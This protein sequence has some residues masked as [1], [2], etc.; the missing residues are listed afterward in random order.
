MQTKSFPLLTE[1][2]ENSDDEFTTPR[3]PSLL[4]QAP[5]S[6]FGSPTFNH[7]STLDKE[8]YQRTARQS[9]KRRIPD[10]EHDDQENAT[11]ITESSEGKG[12]CLQEEKTS[13][14]KRPC[15]DSTAPDAAEDKAQQEVIACIFTGLSKE[16]RDSFYRNITRVIEAGLLM[17]H[18]QDQPFSKETT[19]IITNIDGDALRKTDA[20]LCP[21]MLKY[22]HGMISGSWIVRHEWFVDS[23]NTRTWIPLPHRDYLIQGDTQ[24]GPAPGTQT[25]REIRSRRSLKLF[26][27]SRM[28]F[29]GTFGS[30]GQRAFTKDELLRLLR[31]GGAETSQRRPP[32]KRPPLS[33]SRPVVFD[34][35]AKETLSARE[36]FSSDRSFLY[37]SEDIKPWEVPIDRAA[38]II[39]CDPTS[40][41]PGPL[42][43]LSPVDSRI[44]GWLRDHQ[45]ISLTWLLNCI[46]CSLMGAH[47]IEL[48][49]GSSDE[50]DLAF[51]R[52]EMHRL[53][54]A[55]TLW[56]N[57]K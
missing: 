48:L 34:T 36:Y 42:S 38:P 57:K 4:L 31:D 49:Y 12:A 47:D 53:S 30:S 29:H 14:R 20:K 43:A 21:R 27:S 8:A 15:S 13:T 22:L 32:A 28:F 40:T 50:A 26:A 11:H 35:S 44:H 10:E 45:A 56:R 51:A 54:Q 17:E 46:S 33:S 39:V 25:R 1:V 6:S 37:V 2:S 19:H 52:E 23:I 41:P 18:I 7:A 9:K 5:Q 24:F 3:M 55:W 16:Q